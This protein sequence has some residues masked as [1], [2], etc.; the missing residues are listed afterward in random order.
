MRVKFVRSQGPDASWFGSALNE[1][2]WEFTDL[3]SS[4]EQEY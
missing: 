4:L 2:N 3:I 1:G